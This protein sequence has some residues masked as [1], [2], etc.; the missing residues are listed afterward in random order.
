MS[1]ERFDFGLGHR[2]RVAFAVVEDEFLG[3]VEGRF[4]YLLVSDLPQTSVTVQ[5]RGTEGRGYLVSE[6]KLPFLE[7]GNERGWPD[8]QRETFFLFAERFMTPH[9]PQTT[10]RADT[11][12]V[13]LASRVRRARRQAAAR[14]VSDRARASSSRPITCRL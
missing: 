10:A 5:D 3:P 7:R 12:P 2:R 8:S 9:R 13:G 11:S 6:R 4:A 14:T 1:Q